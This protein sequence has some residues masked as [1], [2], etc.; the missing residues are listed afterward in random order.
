[1]SRLKKKFKK[2]QVAVVEKLAADSAQASD[3]ALEPI[4]E[5]RDVRNLSM[6]K[7]W[8]S[9]KTY[10]AISKKYGLTLQAVFD[11]AKKD[12][13]KG[14]RRELRNR[15]FNQALERIRDMTM[16]VQD[17]LHEDINRLLKDVEDKKRLLTKEERDHLRSMY[18]RSLKEVRLD[19][20]K[21]T[22]ISS[23]PSRVEIV[24]P[25][26]AK[27][28]GLIPPNPKTVTLIEA[29]PEEAK[30]DVDSIESEIKGK[31]K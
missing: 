6:L 20:G 30:I 15:Q 22:E 17:A 11:V 16:D 24:L 2:E 12:N 25:A 18:D 8:L 19:E 9:G 29:S 7:E 10:Q 14:L 4:V 21:P 26:G 31:I 27:R 28:F 3:K 13:W 23:G 5:S 1:M